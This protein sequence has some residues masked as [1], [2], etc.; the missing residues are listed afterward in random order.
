MYINKIVVIQA[1]RGLIANIPVKSV[2]EKKGP[3]IMFAFDPQGESTF[4]DS[5]GRL[6]G[7]SYEMIMVAFSQWPYVQFF[8]DIKILHF[9]MVSRAGR[10]VLVP[11]PITV[12]AITGEYVL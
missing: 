7:K 3:V 12:N 1:P 9:Y 2:D 6:K 8:F 11:F 5:H 10:S 4:M